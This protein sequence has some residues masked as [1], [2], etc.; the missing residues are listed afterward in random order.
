[1]YE[2][3]IKIIYEDGSEENLVV[4]D[5]TLD[6]EIFY[7]EIGDKKHYIPYVSIKKMIVW[8]VDTEE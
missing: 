2:T 1:M 4:D 5:I 3:H 8:D 6:S 7:V